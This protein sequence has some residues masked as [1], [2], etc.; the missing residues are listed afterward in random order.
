MCTVCSCA[1]LQ[2]P[3]SAASEHRCG[4]DSDDD[5]QLQKRSGVLHRA[6]GRRTC[7]HDTPTQNQAVSLLYPAADAGTVFMSATFTY[8]A[9]ATWQSS[10]LR[11]V[12]Q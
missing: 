5:A 6:F 9:T 8:E 2:W 3:M 7:L 4:T 10:C 11:T 12:R 1:C